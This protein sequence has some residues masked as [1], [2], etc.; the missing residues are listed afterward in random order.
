MTYRQAGFIRLPV[1]RLFGLE[2]P[3]EADTQQYQSRRGKDKYQPGIP[4]PGSPGQ[5]VYE[6]G[7]QSIVVYTVMPAIHRSQGGIHQ[8]GPDPEPESGTA[9]GGG[10]AQSSD[11]W[12]IAQAKHDSPGQGHRD[13][14]HQEIDKI[15][16]CLGSATGG[17]GE[18]DNEHQKQALQR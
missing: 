7:G 16:F 5:G 10:K 3:G 14:A 4:G 11:G 6:R 13:E 9:A 12:Q 17:S 2:M 1:L 15:I 8:D 18:Y